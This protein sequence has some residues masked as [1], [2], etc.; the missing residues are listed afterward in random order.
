MACEAALLVLSAAGINRAAREPDLRKL[1]QAGAACLLS[2]FS[3]DA[4]ESGAATRARNAMLHAVGTLTLVVSC[5]DGTGPI[6]GTAFDAVQREPASVVV[7]TGPDAPAGN[8]AL[9]ELGARQITAIDELP[10]LLS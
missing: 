9:A 6:W 8:H 5:E 2:P 7:V 4:A 10:A 3:P 1:V